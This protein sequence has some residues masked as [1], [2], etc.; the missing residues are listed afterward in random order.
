M[1]LNEYLKHIERNLSVPYPARHDLVAEIDAHLHDL[2]ERF[3]Q[4]GLAEDLAVERAIAEMALDHEI[5]G[6]L[7]D[8]HAPLVRRVLSRLPAPLSFVVEQ[9][10]T[11]SLAMVALAVTLFKER[12]MVSFIVSGGIWMIPICLMGL[13]ILGIAGERIFSVFL[14]KDHSPKN[15]RRGLLSLRFLGL[16]SALTGMI[17]TLCGYFEAFEAADRIMQKNGGVFP[18]WYVSKYAVTTT[19]VGLTFGL[20]A[21]VVW[22]VL[23]AVADRI[24]QMRVS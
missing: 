15:L 23:S 7:D 3:R 24:E 14:E 12:Y 2:Y 13:A 9:M 1:T 11:S 5:L 8:I 6:S 21:L 20:V 10:T 16:A 19:M 18:I 17:G 4:H 22:Y